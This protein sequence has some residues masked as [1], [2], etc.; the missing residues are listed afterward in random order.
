[1]NLPFVLGLCIQLFL[2]VIIFFLEI[3]IFVNLIAEEVIKFLHFTIDELRHSDV[4]TE[5]TVEVVGSVIEGEGAICDV[6]V[7]PIV[8]TQGVDLFELLVMREI[9]RFV[10]YKAHTILV[11]QLVDLLHVVHDEEALDAEVVLDVICNVI[12]VSLKCHEPR[13]RKLIN[14]LLRDLV[15]L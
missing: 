7:S 3:L 11:L 12:G 5:L 8:V 4:Y 13:P 9:N 15:R 2:I 1:M 14:L 10:D 6:H